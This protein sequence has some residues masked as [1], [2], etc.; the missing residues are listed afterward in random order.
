[1]DYADFLA[2]K[3]I[4]IAPSGFDVEPRNPHLFPF[5][6]DLVRWALRIGKAAIWA[7]CGL[8]KS[9]ME[10]SWAEHVVKQFNAPVLILAPLSV[11]H[12]TAREGEKFGIPARV[13]ASQSEVDGPGIYITNYEKLHHFDPSVFPGICLDES[14]C[15]KSFT[16]VT[17]NAL[18]VAF[19]NTPMK[20]CC[21]ATPAPNDR[22]ELGNHSEFLGVL[23]RTEML[24]TFFVHDGGDTS[25]WR[26]KGHAQEEYWRWMCGWA[27]MMRKPSDLGY[28]DDG[29]ILPPLNYHHHVVKSEKNLDGF[30]FPVEAQTLIERRGARRDSITERV[31]LTASLVLN[32]T[33]GKPASAQ[34]VSREQA[35]NRQGE[36]QDLHERVSASESREVESHAG[37]A[38]AGPSEKA[39][40]V[41]NRSRVSRKSKASIAGVSTPQPEGEKGATAKKVQPDSGA[42]GTNDSGPAEPLLDMQA[43]GEREQVDVSLCGLLPQNGQGS[44]TALRKLQSRSRE[45]QGLYTATP[46][47]DPIP[48]AQWVIW[49]GLNAEQDALAKVLGDRCVSIYGSLSD[50]E[51]EKRLAQWLNGEKQFLLSKVSIFGWGLNLQQCANVAFLGLSDS[52]EELYQGV[53][54]CWRFGQKSPVNCHVIT[55]E[56]EGAVVKNIQRKEADAARMAKEMVKHMS[57]YNTEAVRGTVR[58]SDTYRTQAERGE[59]WEMRLG[60]CVEHIKDVPDDSVHY[61]IFSP[62]FMALYVYNSSERDMGNVRSDAEFQTHFGFLVG[63]L[64]RVL[65]PGRLISLHCMDIPAMKERDGYIGL[66]DFPGDLIR[67]FEAY[68][69]I[70]HSRVAIWKD[71]LIEATRTKALGLMHKQV[72]KDSA[73]S[74]QG[75]PD[76]L[77]TMRKKGD[78]TEPV[79]RPDGFTSFIGDDEPNARKGDRVLKKDGD[80]SSYLT[81]DDPVYSH[82]VWRRYASPVWM[83]INPSDT[84]QKESAREQADERHICPLQLQVIR[85]GIDLWTNPGDLVLDPFMGIG[86]TG[87]V[88]LQHGRRTLGFELKQSY[89]KQ[90]VANLRSVEHAATQEGLFATG[91]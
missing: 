71:P 27:V 66:K 80:R 26:L 90:A 58:T 22:M 36:A 89:F 76:Y 24:S 61:S 64:C 33:H 17:R 91:D 43:T 59:G 12:Q 70:Y 57:V 3:R 45:I 48:S 10:L 47:G 68:G 32:L 21:S 44:G 9:L 23:T 37:A 20:L 18:I 42:V 5:Q 65:K 25:K 69:F 83:D 84:L 77:I 6:R 28:S 39:F 67:M 79:K 41:S 53:R 51:K 75:L 19:A 56:A 62:P 2:S 82:A 40:T 55:S 54:R 85:R 13:V 60:D 30:L 15:L 29:F 8:G 78:N 88:A 4:T 49:C 34:V 1:M 86:S 81:R 50:S 14:S 11:S 38:S 73:M 63:E 52:F 87:Y 74:R 46:S 72:I 7:D 16:S 31:A 35:S